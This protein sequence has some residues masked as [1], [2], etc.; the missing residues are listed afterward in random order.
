MPGGDGTGP[1]GAGGRWNCRRGFG[2]GLGFGRR[3]GRGYGRG[4]PASVQ[5]RFQTAGASGGDE[6]GELR[7][8]ADELSAE[9]DGV[10][11][12]IAELEKD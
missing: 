11:K 3:Y 10:K 6:A 4:Y 8:Y 5:T 2:I 9:L 12:R 7:A 1:F